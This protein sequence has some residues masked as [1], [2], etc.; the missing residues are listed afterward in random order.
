MRS[1]PEWIGRNDDEKV[2]L[3]VRLRVYDRGNGHCP[4]CT[5]KLYYGRW[6]ID[7]IRSLE[8]GGQHREANLEAICVGCHHRKTGAEAAA[9]AQS[10]RAHANDIGATRKRTGFTGWR[11]FDGTPVYASSKWG[12]WIRQGGGS[13]D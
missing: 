13:D 12:K 10:R 8:S 3:R 2:P 7:H 6:Q 5:R 1:V 4:R 9:R 11:R